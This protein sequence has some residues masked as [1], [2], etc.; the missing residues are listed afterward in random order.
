MRAVHPGLASYI[1]KLHRDKKPSSRP[2]DKADE[3][4]PSSIT[5]DSLSEELGP[6]QRG[7]HVLETEPKPRGA[8]LADVLDSVGRDTDG[9]LHSTY[10]CRKHEPLGHESS[11]LHV[12]RVR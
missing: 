9:S 8:P 3:F 12:I 7:R 1:K 5:M 6:A 4:H 11:D 10:T 2:S